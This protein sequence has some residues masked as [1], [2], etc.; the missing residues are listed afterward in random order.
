MIR[1]LCLV[2]DARGTTAV[3]FALVAPVMLMT[4]MGLFDMGHAQYTRA[5]LEGAIDKASRAA[6]IEGSSTTSID[7]RV[8]TVV[9]QIA[10]SATLTFNRTTYS[11]FSDVGM[12]E[13]FDDVDKDGTC[14]NGEPFE[15]AN[16]NGTYDLDRGKT[17]NGGARDA[18]LYT[19]SVSYKRILPIGRLIGQSD[20][21]KMSVTSV[22]RNQPYG[23]QAFTETKNCP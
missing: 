9:K 8:T 1:Q 22:L 13:D 21:M 14:D 6:T 4:I 2:R 17:G 15:D 12:P 7:A 11:D 16:G 19:V 23:I 20:T 10:P 18:V 3:E 5:L